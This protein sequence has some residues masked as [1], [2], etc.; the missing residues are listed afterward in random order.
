LFSTWQRVAGSFG[1]G[2]IA[3]LYAAQARERGPVAA[4]H[5]AGLVLTGIAL[6]GALAAVAL[7][8]VSNTALARH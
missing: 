1:I 8:A 3:A 6:A 2:L 4:L 7:P 5:A